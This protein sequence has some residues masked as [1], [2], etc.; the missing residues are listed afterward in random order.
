VTVVQ[1]QRREEIMIKAIM[2]A[3]NRDFMM[4]VIAFI[5]GNSEPIRF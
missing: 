2:L 5:S 3:M 1:E 4:L